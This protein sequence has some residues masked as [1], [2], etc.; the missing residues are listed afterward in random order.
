L[1]LTQ[2]EAETGMRTCL[3][4]PVLDSIV[5]ST[6][7]MQTP[8]VDEPCTFRVPIKRM[9]TRVL[10][11]SL[12]QSPAGRVGRNAEHPRRKTTACW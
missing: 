3:T 6:E 10:S 11:L 9:S 7:A 4:A 2:I 5:V 1:Q 8:F 12:S